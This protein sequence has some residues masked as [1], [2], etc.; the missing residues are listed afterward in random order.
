MSLHTETYG[1]GPD[2]VMVHGWGVNSGVWQPVLPLLEKHY[3]VTCVDLPGHGLS[4]ETRMAASLATVATQVL[5]IAPPAA[6]WLGWSLGGLVCLQIAAHFPVRVCALI[7]SNTTPRFIAAPDWRYAMPVA[8]LDAFAAELGVD[9]ADTVRGFLALQ[10]LGDEHAR[11]TLRALRESVLLCGEPD[12]SSLAAGLSMLRDSDVRDELVRITAPTLV[13]SGAY[14]RLT[15]P[16][17]G[18]F[19]AA[20]ITAAELVNFPRTAHAPFI[21]HP[22]DFVRVLNDFTGRK[23]PECAHEHIS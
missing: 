10:V 9:Y 11:E 3:R 20:T 5:A 7:L 17:A 16:Q 18:E 2:L 4:A 12:P 22:F 19:M 1:A 8:Q 13:L 15:P 23:I 6:I 21:S 14:D